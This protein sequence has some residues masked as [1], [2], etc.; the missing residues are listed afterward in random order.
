MSIDVALQDAGLDVVCYRGWE[1]R[2]RPGKWNPRAL[3]VHHTGRGTTGGLV[4]LCINGRADLAGPLC[5]V[6]LDPEGTCH[7]IAAGRANHAGL[8]EWRGLTS[9]N[10]SMWAIEA[11]NAGDGRWPAEQLAA[12]V[13]ASAALARFGGFGADMVAAHK[14]YAT[15]KGRKI[16]PAGIDMAWFR[17][18]VDSWLDRWARSPEPKGVRPMHDP[19]LGP[20]AAS[21]QDEAGRVLAQVSPDGDVYA[22]AVPWSGNVRGKPYWG[23]R[24]VALIGPPSRPG[25]VY[26]ITATDGGTYTMPDGQDAGVQ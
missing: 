2:G 21:W 15:P 23:N 3:L 8:G 22:W 12:F 24:K 25:G 7:L 6:V 10:A 13:L 17:T 9:G 1:D 5:H 20:M 14:E 26:D 4:Q 16:D 11:V 19:P 18:R